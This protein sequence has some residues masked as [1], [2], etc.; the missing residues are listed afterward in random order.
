MCVPE[1]PQPILDFVKTAPFSW[2]LGVSG[3]ICLSGVLA[4]S[5]KWR[6]WNLDWS[7]KARVF[8]SALGCLIVGVFF[9]LFQG[10]CMENGQCDIKDVGVNF[11]GILLAVLLAYW[12]WKVLRQD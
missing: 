5:T 7:F 8:C 6:F 3:L 2:H 10:C 12:A 1:S 9:E 4:L 11:L